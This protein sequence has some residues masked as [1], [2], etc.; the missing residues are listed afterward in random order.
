MQALEW[1]YQ[2][3][4]QKKVFELYRKAKQNRSS[5]IAELI[6]ISS[7]NWEDRLL[8]SICICN[9]RQVVK[10]LGLHFEDLEIKYL[11]RNR[12]YSERLHPIAKCLYFLCESL[13]IEETKKLLQLVKKD[14]VKYE[15]LLED[16]DHLELHLLY[17][18]DIGYI[19][20]FSAKKG[21]LK[22]LLKHLKTF[23]DLESIII[24]LKQFDSD[25]STSNIG[26][27]GEASSLAH[28]ANL[29]ETDAKK[30]I[31]R[32]NKGLCVIINQM[33]FQ[34]SQYETRFGT[35]ADSAELCKTFKG[36]GFTV[37]VF[38]DLKGNDML[39]NIR[40]IP[41]QFGSDYD[42]IFLCILSHGYKG[43]VIA[44]DEEEISIESIDDAF[45]CSELR[46]VIKIVIIQACQGKTAGK[47]LNHGNLTTDGLNDPITADITA[48]RNFCIFMSTL[49]GF[50]SVRDKQRGSWFI[51]EL[52]SILQRKEKNQRFFEC[53]T[54]VM[55]A[56]Q[57]KRGIMD[58]ESVAQLPEL[59]MCRLDTDFELPQYKS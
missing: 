52:C 32:I 17:W 45:C 36:F 16:V 48:K 56:I 26:V 6:K 10:K 20:I 34:G 39:L 21:N 19:S 9:N 44:T 35:N 43:G 40:N 47:V 15:P 50:V 46:E 33:Y 41:K 12:L 2:Q 42:C 22:N 25:Q 23:E 8:E 18:M 13:S 4:L 54:E 55:Q 11:P 1:K 49:Q 27:S 30:K 57:N 38:D 37:Y 58:G 29:T 31:R 51:Q 28:Q 14:I 24:D 59:R 3:I 7:H 5:V 53:I